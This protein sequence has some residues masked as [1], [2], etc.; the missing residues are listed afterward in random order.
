VPCEF[1]RVLVSKAACARS[2]AER[3]EG[4]SIG[5]ACATSH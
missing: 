5:P 2:V 3:S 1:S 4:A